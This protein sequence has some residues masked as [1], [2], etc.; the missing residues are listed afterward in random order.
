MLESNKSSN[1]HDNGSSKKVRYIEGNSDNFGG[2]CY[3]KEMK[4][5]KLNNESNKK[6]RARDN[7]MKGRKKEHGDSSD[8]EKKNY[9]IRRLKE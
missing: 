3:R 1:V 2:K 4:L 7:D 9:H 6:K 8:D 5:S